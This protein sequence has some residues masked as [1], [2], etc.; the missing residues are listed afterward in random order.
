[1]YTRNDVTN[2]FCFSANLTYLQLV[3]ADENDKPISNMF[4]EIYEFIRVNTEQ[5]GSE[6]P[7]ADVD[8]E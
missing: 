7:I 4:E 6:E 2:R 1:M 5:T 3:V 8:L